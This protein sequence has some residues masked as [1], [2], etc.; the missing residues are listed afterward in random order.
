MYLLDIRKMRAADIGSGKILQRITIN[1]AVSGDE[2]VIDG[3]VQIP[4]ENLKQVDIILS[5][6][7]TNESLAGALNNLADYFIKEK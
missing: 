3:V 4:S 7:I 6:P 1:Y 5:E 2:K